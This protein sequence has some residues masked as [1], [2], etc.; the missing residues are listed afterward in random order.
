MKVRVLFPMLATKWAESVLSVMGKRF[1]KEEGGI[2][3]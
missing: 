3:G 2:H 1:I